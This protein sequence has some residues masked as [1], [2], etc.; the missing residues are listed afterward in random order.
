MT[1]STLRGV[2]NGLRTRVARLRLHEV[3]WSAVGLGIVVAMVSTLLKGPNVRFEMVVETEGCD[4]RIGAE[5]ATLRDV[6]AQWAKIFEPAEALEPTFSNPHRDSR[7]GSDA[8]SKRAVEIHAQSG[9]FVKLQELR[10][11]PRS[12]L[13]VRQLRREMQLEIVV[14]SENA[15]TL[16]SELLVASTGYNKNSP[17]KDTD[18]SMSSLQSRFFPGTTVHAIFG[19]ATSGMS[20]G[21]PFAVTALQFVKQ[22]SYAQRIY[23]VSMITGG[24]I[25]FFLDSGAQLSSRKFERGTRIHL[26]LSNAEVTSME[27][28]VDGLRIRVMGTAHDV[29]AIRGTSSESLYPSAFEV[30]SALPIA[31]FIAATLAAILVGLIGSPH[32]PTSA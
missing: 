12:A 20:M 25:D 8:P 31:R 9:G 14:E 29:L 13:R 5:P 27:A 30:A 18:L 24:R 2:W 15:S 1:N 22:E 7:Q 23:P 21:P 4:L 3:G 26:D 32:Q 10:V 11:P 28:N 19:N 17:E 6:D 16:D